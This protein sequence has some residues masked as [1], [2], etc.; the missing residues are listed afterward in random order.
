MTPSAPRHYLPTSDT[1]YDRGRLYLIVSGQQIA[2]AGEVEMDYTTLYGITTLVDQYGGD[3]PYIGGT[4]R[5]HAYSL[6]DDGEEG[7]TTKYDIEVVDIIDR[8]VPSLKFEFRERA[9]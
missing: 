6:D 7:P 1:L 3:Q 9:A 5:L 8:D 2:V 4:Y